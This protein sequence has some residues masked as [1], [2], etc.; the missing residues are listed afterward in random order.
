MTA[1]TEYQRLE[2]TGLWRESPDA[3][4]REVVVSLGDATL[5]VS[6]HNDQALA[7]WSLPA[8]ERLNP[9]ETPALYSPGLE[10]QETLELEDPEM[11]AAIEKVRVVLA[12]RHAKPGRL[13]LFV[14]LA[15]LGAL[16]ALAYSKLPETLQTHT[17]RVVPDAKRA[18][19]GGEVLQRLSRLTGQ[20]CA[21]PR[22]TRALT[23]LHA[24]LFPNTN[25]RILVLPGGVR[26]TA[27]LPGGLIL[28]AR[29]L[30]EDFDEPDVV[31]GHILAEHLTRLDR[32]PLKPLLDHAG[33]L[34]TF[35]LYTTGSI[36]A[37]ALDGYAE[38]FVTSTSPAPETERLLAAFKLAEVPSSPYAYALDVSGETT[39]E[40][41]EADPFPN[42]GPRA[43]LPDGAWI[44][45][46]SICAQ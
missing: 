27:H 36:P 15:T 1:L 3:Q 5:I 43:V 44:S 17:M 14:I 6:H 25:G 2:S 20:P 9:N 35:R 12:K 11:V 34:A 26:S 16:G 40:L 19:I 10:A 31:A 23:R 4:R 42:G 46:Q 32:D 45:L 33:F 21:S 37:E 29:S 41:I 30:V 8:V 24:R 22:G 39:L 28:V 18:E 13:R 7:H 38:T